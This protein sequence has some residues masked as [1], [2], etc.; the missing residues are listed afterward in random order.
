MASLGRLVAAV[1]HELNNPISFVLGNMQA[2]ARYGERIAGYLEA[3]HGDAAPERRQRLRRELR[4]DAALA[5]L[6]PL[7]AGTVEGATR[8]RDI[9][10]G[11]SRF[12][13]SE[14]GESAP[15]P[16]VTVLEKA[17]HWVT[18]ASGAPIDVIMDA[19][20]DCVIRGAAGEIQQVFMNLVH[21][22]IDATDGRPEPRLAVRVRATP[23]HVAIVFADNGPGFR[24]EE[25]GR[26]FE[27]FFTTKPVGPG[28]GLGLSI[29]Y[30]I[31]ARHAGTIV[32][33][34]AV[35]GGAQVTVRLPLQ[36]PEP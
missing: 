12:S 5:D 21:N 27:P 11:L 14:R 24:G 33:G 32:A 18:R 30:G 16:L 7:I 6:P 9:V 31:V 4:I 2:L 10:A 15:F 8:T 25:I 26:V 22:A 1:A 23:E 17:I 13:A 20:G 19:S 29:S 34:S 3:V 28:T 35:E 36:L